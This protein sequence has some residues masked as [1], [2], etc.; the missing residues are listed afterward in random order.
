MVSHAS[1]YD[2]IENIFAITVPHF[3][4]SHDIQELEFHVN[5]M[6]IVYCLRRTLVS[7]TFKTHV[8]RAVCFLV[9]TCKH[10]KKIRTDLKIFT[11]LIF[12]LFCKYC[13][14]SIIKLKFVL[15]NFKLIYSKIFVRQNYIV[16]HCSIDSVRF[17]WKQGC[18]F[19]PFVS[20]VVCVQL[21]V[22]VCVPFCLTCF[23]IP[24]ALYIVKQLQHM[25][26]HSETHTGCKKLSPEGAAQ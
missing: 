18:W 23:T 5:L 6:D 25:H 3:L 11:L 7:L 10:R 4:Y 12:C 20:V 15:I 2:A 22:C 17:V 21:S 13:I 9:C 19:I 14:F 24:N 16:S 1:K 26:T 8:I